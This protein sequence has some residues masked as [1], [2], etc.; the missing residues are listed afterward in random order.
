MK[1]LNCL[2]ILFLFFLCQQTTGQQTK[3]PGGY[4]MLK[5]TAN[6]GS[7][8][9]AFSN[10]QFKIYT[11]RHFM[12]V[13]QH[14]NDSLCDYGIG[15]YKAD[16]DKVIENLIYSTFSGD[17]AN[18]G[19]SILLKITKLPKGYRQVIE[20]RD[21]AN[22]PF[23]LTEDYENVSKK[24]RSPLDGAWKQTKNV[25]MTKTDTV[26]NHNTQYKVYQSGNF[27]WAST[28]KDSATSKP[29]S[30][31]GYGTFKMDGKNK[32]TEVNQNSTFKSM[33]VGQPI[34]VDIEMM[35][36]DAYKQK[37]TFPGGNVG[38]ETYERLK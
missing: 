19:D 26:T 2:L 22:R 6:F 38:E 36:P 9:T 33:L 30:F 4:K 5:Q 32:S 31:F 23:L 28:D 29:V 8:D 16:G 1:P 15:T 12:F 34:S 24:T 17:P 13:S 10:D 3:M 18:Q 37:I 25:F 35:G 11:D 21:S 27:I 20:F 7:G 14:I